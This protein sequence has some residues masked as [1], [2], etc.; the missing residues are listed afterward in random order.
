M[1][2]QDDKGAGQEA[3]GKPDK[4][5]END[6]DRADGSLPE[7]PE[8]DE[9]ARNAASEMMESYKDKAT[10]V[11][12]GS[13]GAVSGTAVNEWLD[14]DGNPKYEVAEGA[15]SAKADEAKNDEKKQEQIEK[16]KALNE[17]LKEAAT[18]E[19]KGEKD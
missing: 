1:T 9:N 12:P 5:A 18:Q 11:L 7:M 2:V 4:P 13:G 15:D 17:K 16:D 3:E 14:D 6:T 10:I 8:I 19:N